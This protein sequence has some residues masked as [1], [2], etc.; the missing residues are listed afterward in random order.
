M[1][2]EIIDLHRTYVLTSA[3]RSA[4]LH[5]LAGLPELAATADGRS[6]HVQAEYE[7]PNGHEQLAATFDNIG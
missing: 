2:I 1:L 6:V 3:E 7:S 4:T 5:V